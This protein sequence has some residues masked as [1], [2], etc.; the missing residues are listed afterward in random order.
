M[1]KETKGKKIRLKDMQLEDIREQ[2]LDVLYERSKLDLLGD[3][4]SC[5]EPGG[6]PA[7]GGGA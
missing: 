6:G 3:S 7:G 2:N 4:S 1:Q 5:G